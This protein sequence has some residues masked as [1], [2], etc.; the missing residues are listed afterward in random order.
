MAWLML[1]QVACLRNKTVDCT[2]QPCLR[3]SPFVLVILSFG[4]PYY[5]LSL[6]LEKQAGGVL[7][8]QPKSA[9]HAT[10]INITQQ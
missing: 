9:L 1:Q 4:L 2:C 3:Q 10:I 5:N 8:I 7:L 6:S